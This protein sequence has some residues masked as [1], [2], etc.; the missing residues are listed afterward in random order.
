MERA[1]CVASHENDREE[2]EYAAE[3]SFNSIVGPPVL[4]RRMLYLDL[5]QLKAAITGKHGYVAVTLAVDHHFIEHFS[6]IALQPAID[7]VQTY[8]CQKRCGAIVNSRPY[9]LR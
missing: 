2:T 8:A 1:V 7:V 5:A 9:A 6:A 3:H 4:A